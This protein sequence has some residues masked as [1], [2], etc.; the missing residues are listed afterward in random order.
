MISLLKVIFLIGLGF[1]AGQTYNPNAAEAGVVDRVVLE[2]QG[3]A[4]AVDRVGER[5]ECAKE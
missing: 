2:L 5:L 4:A 1:F 3:I